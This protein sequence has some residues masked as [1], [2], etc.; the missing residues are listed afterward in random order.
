MDSGENNIEVNCSKPSTDKFFFSYTT[1][2]VVQVET[3]V[4]MQK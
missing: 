2:H 4:K 1:N 3:L